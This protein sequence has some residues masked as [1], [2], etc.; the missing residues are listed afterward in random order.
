MFKFFEIS[1]TKVIIGQ[2]VFIGDLEEYVSKNF[3]GGRPV[4]LYPTNIGI[5]LGHIAYKYGDGEPWEVE[6]KEIAA[7]PEFK[8]LVVLG[9]GTL[10]PYQKD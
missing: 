6:Y 10:Y 5:F 7:F 3:N 2:S 4:T 9:E 8:H 1:N